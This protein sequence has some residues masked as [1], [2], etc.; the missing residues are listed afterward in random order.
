MSKKRNNAAK[1]HQNSAHEQQ[2]KMAAKKAAVLGTTKQKSYLPMLIVGVGIAC[3]VG[4]GVFYVLYGPNVSGSK[5]ISLEQSVAP[6]ATML[7]YP[8]SLFIDGVAKH[9]SYQHGDLTIKYFVLRSS[10]GVIRAAFDA[11][12]V[13]WPAGKGYYQDGD[14]MVCRNCGRRFASVMVN[15]VE[16]GCN[17]SP[18]IRTIQDDEL[19][20]QVEDII[21]GKQYFDFSQHTGA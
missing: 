12:D 4:A 21:K 20:I 10:D 17:P 5:Q 18:L 2:D 7:K 13:C 6:A 14:H 15:E 1:N 16:G 9:F 8:T 3:A 19:I 11:C